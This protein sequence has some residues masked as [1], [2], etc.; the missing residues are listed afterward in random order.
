MHRIIQSLLDLNILSF[1]NIQTLVKFYTEKSMPVTNS[2]VATVNSISKRFFT[3]FNSLETKISLY[4]WFVNGDNHSVDISKTEEFVSR[5][6]AHENVNVYRK[7]IVAEDGHFDLLFNSIEDCILFSE[8]DIDAPEIV[9][10]GELNIDRF[11]IQRGVLS[12]MINDFI[13]TL[14]EH[15]E[16]LKR[17]DIDILRYIEYTTIVVVAMECMIK[18]STNKCDFKQELRESIELAA[19]QMF[20]RSQ[21]VLVS[22]TQIPVKIKLLQRLEDI[23]AA[24]LSPA[25]GSLIRNCINEDFFRCISNIL[26]VDTKD[27]NDDIVCTEDDDLDIDALRHHCVYVLAS[28]CRIPGP[29]RDELLELILDSKCYTY[30][31]DTHCALRCIEILSDGRVEQ[32][33]I[34]NVLIELKACSY[35][36]FL[37]FLFFIA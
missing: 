17:K 10:Y 9:E 22:N 18:N 23:M 31:K 33:P 27:E 30:S 6:L 20:K 4:S 37:F 5:L 25:L 19:T 8:F 21:D 1:N 2:S 7:K 36:Y 15:I 14:R 34:G 13:T 3:K 35:I 12:H 11:E 28:F 32:P 24:D 26:H 29:Y 16:R